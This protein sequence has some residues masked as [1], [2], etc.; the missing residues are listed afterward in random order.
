M[1]VLFDG[2]PLKFEGC[3]GDGFTADGT[4][5]TYREFMTYIEEIQYSGFHAD[6]LDLAC[7]LSAVSL[8]SVST[9]VTT[10]L[11]LLVIW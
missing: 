6:D 5:C 7:N 1:S 4:G 9:L 8:A 10:I 2:D 3:S 11:L